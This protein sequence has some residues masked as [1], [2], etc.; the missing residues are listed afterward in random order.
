MLC[1]HYHDD[2][3]RAQAVA[4]IAQ[5][6]RQL[7]A[8]LVVLESEATCERTR[9]TVSRLERTTS[10]G[11]KFRPLRFQDEGRVGEHR[12]ADAQGVVRRALQEV[13]DVGDP[14]VAWV[15]APLVPNGLARGKTLC[16][17]HDE[18]ESL[19]A[20]KAASVIIAFRFAHI[21][22][23]DFF[24]LVEGPTVLVSAR[25]LL[26]D[27]PSW[28][29]RRSALD[30]ALGA[31]IAA[32]PLSLPPASLAPASA[33][34]FD[35][36]RLGALGHFAAGMVHELGN[37][38]SIISSSLQYLHERLATTKDPASDFTMM[39]LQN[40]ERMH[41]LLHSMVDFA[42]V[43]RLRFQPIDLKETISEVL[44]FTSAECE[45][46]N[47]AVEVTFDP[48]L[49]LAS[50]DA[51][52]VKQVLLNLVK[53]V[54]D[55]LLQ[56]GNALRIRARL[57]AEDRLAV[58]EVENEGPCI[59]AEVLPNL[60]LPFHTTKDRGT[61][62][63][64]YLSRQLARDHGGDLQAANVPDGVRFTLTLPLEQPKT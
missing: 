20:E 4:S 13:F 49:P 46:R 45:R 62:L 32:S 61:G 23:R 48:L 53:N 27:C 44:R 22:L 54:L 34:G 21:S 30:L 55:A 51:G 24:G 52:A 42:A 5:R 40:V 39:A 17:F 9:A 56:D 2:Q 37:P 64:L 58:V 1:I 38:L 14:T 3:E 50:V 15:E 33:A 7:D 18:L 31:P 19:V 25:M 43:K 11:V 29:I 12:A 59:P 16:A 8:N 63:G 36:D 47:I 41:A 35:E 10:P 6:C 60:F 26:P 28:L 57:R